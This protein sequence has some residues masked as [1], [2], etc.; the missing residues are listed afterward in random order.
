MGR[1]HFPHELKNVFKGGFL[2]DRWD[3]YQSRKRQCLIDSSRADSPQII[4]A[5]IKEIRESAGLTRADLCELLGLVD[6]KKV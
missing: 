2:M 4:G 3:N 5:R 6:E 1:N